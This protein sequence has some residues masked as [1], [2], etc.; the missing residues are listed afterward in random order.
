MIIAEVVDQMAHEKL[1]TFI[2]ARFESYTAQDL[3]HLREIL[4]PNSYPE[5]AM[6]KASQLGASKTVAKKQH[7]ARG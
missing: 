4:N 1:L 7:N 5:E 2:K 3:M 6:P